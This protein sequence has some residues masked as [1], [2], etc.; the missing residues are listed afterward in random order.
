MMNCVLWILTRS[1][2]FLFN[3]MLVSSFLLAACGA[4]IPQPGSTLSEPP[5]Y[6]TELSNA[7]DACDQVGLDQVCFGQGTITVEP[8][9]NVRLE[10]FTQPGDILALANITSVQL[11]AG[12]GNSLNADH[13]FHLSPL[14]Q[15]ASRLHTA[16]W[17]PAFDSVSPHAFPLQSPATY[18]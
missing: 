13:I 17:S 11:E 6:M 15:P 12:A 16:G 9:P 14:T 18:W 2:N 3:G 10:E 1:K 7:L 4:G 8:Q 5:A